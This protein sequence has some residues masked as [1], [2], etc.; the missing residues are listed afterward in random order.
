[1]SVDERRASG[2]ERIPF[3]ALVAVDAECEGRFECEALDLSAGGLRVRSA[4]LPALG[5]S[6]RCRF[7]VGGAERHAGARVVWKTEQTRGGEFGL[8]FDGLEPGAREA[9]A[10]FCGVAP[11]AASRPA[12][13]GDGASRPAPAG[14]GAARPGGRVVDKG[15]RVRLHIEGLA[16]PMRARVQEAETG[17]L[18]VG[19]NLEFLSLGRPLSVEDVDKGKNL[20][21]VI[22]EV[23]VRVDPSSQVPQLRVSL[24]CDK[25]A[26]AAN[27]AQPAAPLGQ[28]V[29]VARAP[30]PESRRHRTPAWGSVVPSKA[31]QGEDRNADAPAAARK[32]D[33]APGAEGR[34]TDMISRTEGRKTETLSGAETRKIETPVV[35]EAL[36]ALDA[37]PPGQGAPGDAAAGGEAVAVGGEA[38]AVGGEA[39]AGGGKAE[40][41]ASA[42]DE[43]AGEG[44]STGKA[45]AVMAAVR[46][47][48]DRLGPRLGT[49]AERARSATALVFR[50]LRKEEATTLGKRTTTQMPFVPAAEGRRGFG[51]GRESTMEDQHEA[52]QDT[53]AGERGKGARRW[54]VLGGAGVAAALLATLALRTRGDA[55]PG[56]DATRPPEVSAVAAPADG[57]LAAPRPVAVAGE[58]V[59]ANVPLFG[60]TPLSTI[61]AV[62]VPPGAP[63]P[64]SFAAN[65]APAA[66]GLAAPPVALPAEGQGA[67]T[68]GKGDVRRARTVRL[69]MDAPVGALRGNVVDGNLVVTVLGRHNIEPASPLARRDPRLTSVK[70]VPVGDDTEVTLSFKGDV[71]PFLAKASGRTLEIDLG[72]ARRASASAS[73]DDGDD[74]EPRSKKRRARRAHDAA[75]GR[76]G[77]KA[78]RDAKHGGKDDKRHDASSGKDDKRHDASNGKDDK[79][80]GDAGKDDKRHDASNGKDDKRRGD[81]GKDDKR[82][83]DSG[84]KRHADSGDKRHGDAGKED[85]RHESS[86]KGDKAEKRRGER[87]KHNQDRD[88]EDG[89]D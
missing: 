55:P 37:A 36:E 64:S 71:P 38:A 61:E 4:Y 14:D 23:G 10:A 78:D 46:A 7:D 48:V 9:I 22:D 58:A 19:S 11:D 43:E 82:H 39:A 3:E 75:T 68:Y 69:Q 28:A 29:G 59:T 8:A 84:D 87:P 26:A 34:K 66:G 56:A 51:A 44:V 70:A 27:A 85:K 60:P 20:D 76:H 18:T 49:A 6:L 50:R 81:A 53:T 63:V 80:H 2:N 16:S 74:N 57:S 65:G 52:A 32:T 40:A 88:R 12:P 21:A 54:A 33:E 41:K 45:A 5:R 86:S 24:R 79:R 1:M 42:A 17:K 67:S 72:E 30:A 13:A 25:N 15:D 89:D 73:A 31:R 47:S 77:A 62:A 35:S 83:A